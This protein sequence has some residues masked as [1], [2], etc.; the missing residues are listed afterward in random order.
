VEKDATVFGRILRFTCSGSD[1]ASWIVV[2]CVRFMYGGRLW[3]LGG[4][5]CELPQGKAEDRYVRPLGHGGWYRPPKHVSRSEG[6]QYALSEAVD[7]VVE[8]EAYSLFRWLFRL[9]Y[10]GLFCSFVGFK[11]FL[12]VYVLSGVQFGLLGFEMRQKVIRVLRSRYTGDTHGVYV[13]AEE[14]MKHK[15]GIR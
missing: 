9:P 5:W 15:V 11:Y 12:L 7:Y 4:L 3:F 1:V 13:V 14:Y 6:Q 10:A 2:L 8:Y